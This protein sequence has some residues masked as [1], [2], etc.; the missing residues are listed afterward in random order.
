MSV[1]LP[2]RDGAAT[3]RAA[4]DSLYAQ[5]F[6]DFRVIAVDDG[7]SDE[8]PRILREAML[9]WGAAAKTAATTGG[10]ATAVAAGTGA[11]AGASTAA[12]EVPGAQP[13]LAVVR[14]DPGAGIA[15]ALIAAAQAAGETE[16]YARQDA[17]DVSYPER[18]ARQVAYL[19]AHPETGLVGTGIHTIIQSAETVGSGERTEARSTEGWR[20]YERWLAE[21]VT[22]EDIA[23]GLWVE[24]PLP[25]P[26]V[27]M[28][29]AAYELAG[30]YREVPWAED[31]DLWLR[32]LRVG[33][34]MAKLPEPLY[35]WADHPG[36]ATRTLPAYAPEAFHACRAH[37]LAR[38]LD[39]R[40]VIVWGAGRDG[41]RA[42]RAMLRQG[43][44]IRAFLDIDPRKIGRTAY[45]RP[46][47]QPQEWLATRDELL[48]LGGEESAITS[49]AAPG[50]RVASPRILAAVGTAGARELIRARLV[51]AGLRE[52]SDFL[53][54]A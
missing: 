21:C 25:H 22:P 34:T 19:D 15:G 46:I 31:Y 36:R 40:G 2:V 14:L 18:F 49:C 37:H 45:G 48:G 54:I 47:L 50:A 29:R 20:R 12:N 5:T 26:T 41:R 43:V 39:G 44:D 24:S 23:R 16:L 51:S 13:L 4:L 35:E 6:R 8:T 27:M 10:A 17:D 52:G 3:L 42:A 38:H 11:E 28:R 33:I 32:M 53:C 1:L 30:G 7:S 9:S